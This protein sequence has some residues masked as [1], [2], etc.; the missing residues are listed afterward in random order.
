VTLV[1]VQCSLFC[2]LIYSLVGDDKKCIILSVLI[3]VADLS[4]ILEGGNQNIEWE[5]VVI[6]DV[7]S[8]SV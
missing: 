5:K 2:Y 6:T 8:I 4:K 1:L 7:M 3:T